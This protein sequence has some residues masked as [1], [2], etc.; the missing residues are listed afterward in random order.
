[1]SIAYL[2]RLVGV[3]LLVGAALYLAHEAGGRGPARR[4]VAIVIA[5]ATVP[6]IVWFARNQWVGATAG[7][8]Y[9]SEFAY[10]SAASFGLAWT[11]PGGWAG[12]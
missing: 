2:T 12:T 1:M 11:S 6:A 5:L 7:T 9:W 8:P 4:R 3:S 10:R